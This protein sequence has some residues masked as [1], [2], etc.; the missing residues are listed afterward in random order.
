MT[1][2]AFACVLVL[3]ATALRATATSPSAT[4]LPSWHVESDWAVYDL[5][6]DIDPTIPQ[7]VTLLRN[8]NDGSLYLQLVN[9]TDPIGAPTGQWWDPPMPSR[10]QCARGCAGRCK[11]AVVAV[12]QMLPHRVP[13]RPRRADAASSH[14]QSRF[15]VSTSRIRPRPDPRCPLHLPIHRRGHRVQRVARRFGPVLERGDAGHA[16]P[17]RRQP[18]S[19]RPVASVSSCCGILRT[20]AVPYMPRERCS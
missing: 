5:S 16:R 15:V 14:R 4:A 3:A 7:P 6:G 10:S 19:D 2:P 18:V 13:A 12:R 11:I 20:R 9:V 17:G 8:P 1:I